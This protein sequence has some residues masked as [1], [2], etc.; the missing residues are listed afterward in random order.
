MFKLG[1]N[2][3]S[4]KSHKHGSKGRH[5]HGHKHR[6]DARRRHGAHK[7]TRKQKKSL[8]KSKRKQS[9][10]LQSGKA[11]FARK[12]KNRTP[13]GSTKGF[14]SK[15]RKHPYRHHHPIVTNKRCNALTAAQCGVE[16][17]IGEQCKN[18]KPAAKDTKNLKKGETRCV[19][20]SRRELGKIKHTHGPEW[21]RKV[22]KKSK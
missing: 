14:S 15:A 16:G 13:K 3:N 19:K 12:S 8:R 22:A 5:R 7:H 9:R 11:R 2:R 4:R 10:G 20:K 21:G 6:G 1:G 18:T 17:T